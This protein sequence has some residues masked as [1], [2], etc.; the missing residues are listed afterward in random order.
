MVRSDVLYVSESGTGLGL[1]SS[2]PTTLDKALKA[3]NDN[4]RII[5]VDSYMLNNTNINRNV[6]LAGYNNTISI[7]RNNT[8]DKNKYLFNPPKKIKNLSLN[9][10]LSSQLL[11]NKK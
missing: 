6:T 9:N 10:Y 4:G 8:T 5:F 7:K 2:E 3:I 1:M 11:K